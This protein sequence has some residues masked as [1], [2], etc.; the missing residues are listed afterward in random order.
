MPPLTRSQT[1][2]LAVLIDA[3]NASARLIEPLLNEV[4]KY[5]TANVKRI[6]GNWT[7]PNLASWK[8]S[9]NKFA[10]QPIQQFG[11]TTGKNAS[12]SALIIDAMDLLHSGNVDGFCIVS[13]DS[14]FTRLACRIRESGLSVYGFGE[15]KTPE[16]FVRACDRFIYV[17][18]LIQEEVEEQPASRPK[19]VGAQTAAASAAKGVHALGPQQIKLI[20]S[21]YD[22]LAP[23]GGWVTLGALGSQLLKLSP[24]F[25]SRT[26]GFKKLS[27]L[28]CSL[29]GFKIDHRTGDGKTGSKHPYVTVK[30]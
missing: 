14:D 7:T 26:Y 22:A 9:L 15:K 30:P 18:N 21:A 12:D 24:S 16:P 28:V 20:R 11:Y 25:D 4:A 8:D 19:P 17:E 23:E 10:I 27:E 5:G 13:S 2:R 29:D 1:I 3:E 6:Y